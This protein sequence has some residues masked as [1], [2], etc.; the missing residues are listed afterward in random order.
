MNPEDNQ[1]NQNGVPI[2]PDV[3]GPAPTP[4][5]TPAPAPEATA[6]EAP[7]LDQVAADLTSAA[8]NNTL[9]SPAEITPAPSVDSSAAEAS[10]PF[11]PT[12]ETPTTSTPTPD[13]TTPEASITPEAPAVETPPAADLATPAAPAAD[14]TLGQVSATDLASATDAPFAAASTPE[15]PSMD[16]PVDT[17]SSEPATLGG[18]PDSS[19]GDS[20]AM[21]STIGT[22]SADDTPTETTPA[23]D[24]PGTETP[25]TPESEPT[26][27]ASFIGDAPKPAESKSDTEEEEPIVPA[28]PV[29]GSIGSALIY[30]ESAPNHAEPVT[31]VKKKKEVKANLKLIV[32]IGAAVVLIAIVIV[33]LMIVLGGGSKK[34]TTNSSSS[35]SSSQVKQPTVSSL[36]CTLEGDGSVF[37]AYGEAVS[38]RKDVIAMYSDDELSSIGSTMVLNY[39]SADAANTGRDLAR[40]TYA[41]K[42]ESAYN[43]GSTTENAVADPF[44]SN[45]EVIGDT[46]TVTHQ[47]DA[48]DINATNAKVLDLFVIRGEVVTDI[49]TI[50][51][52]YE[53]DG[54]TCVVK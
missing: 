26:S 11:A 27:S 20:S 38:G 39:A 4:D 53:E 12:T 35:S 37:P 51:D 9:E 36:T 30:S 7:S 16:A 18:A 19:L 47:A 29:P 5:S 23:S 34:S 46:L 21:D 25:E 8:N 22:S 13:T 31:K 2:S 41:A 3:A 1:N 28:D 14:T 43:N 42:Y 32:I 33:I 50:Q 24:N 40:N 44:I 6:P 45:Y 52:S 48:A 54:F 10:A 49:D 17:L 15:A